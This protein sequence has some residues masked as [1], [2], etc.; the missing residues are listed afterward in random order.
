MEF[1]RGWQGSEGQGQ[2]VREGRGS[3]SRLADTVREQEVGRSN[4]FP[5]ATVDSRIF[6]QTGGPSTPLQIEH[7]PGVSLF[8]SFIYSFILSFQFETG[9]RMVAQAGLE[10]NPSPTCAPGV[11]GL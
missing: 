11:L 1:Y 2:L 9:S 5:M 3:H 6:H 7:L 4:L 10:L 8:L